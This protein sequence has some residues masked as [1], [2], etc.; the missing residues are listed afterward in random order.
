MS[1]SSGCI[2]AAFH[3]GVHVIRLSGDVR[4]NL[5]STL[6]HYVSHVLREKPFENV[7]I[8]LS[9]AI[10]VD[11]TSL[12]QI[13]KISILCQERYALTPTIVSPNPDIT[14]IL[15]SMGFDHVFHIIDKVL[16]GCTELKEWVIESVDEE[17]AREQVISAHK[18]LMSLNQ[19][20]K[21]V[22]QG[23]VDALECSR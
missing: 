9:E 23:L 3:Q 2:E 12:G 11:S 17:E 8:D 20:N 1:L 5:C 21:E 15:N 6:D 10:G 16:S 13:A 18:A 22:F 19:K 14:K 7:I 4:L